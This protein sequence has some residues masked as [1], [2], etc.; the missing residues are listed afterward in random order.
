MVLLILAGRGWG[1]F[2]AEGGAVPTSVAMP[3]S[4]AIEATYGVRVESVAVT[5]GGGMIQVR[6]QILNGDKAE[7]LH[8]TDAAPAV[9]SAEGTVYADP[10]MAGHSHVGKT[11]T[12]GSS[13]TLLLADAGG[14]V[15]RGDVV[16]V[17]IGELVLRGVHVL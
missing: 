5:A 4:A 8:G 16:T 9:I 10:G 6:Y 7:A 2:A 17:R 1:P 12:S 11:G 13:D 3:A 14:A 15:Q